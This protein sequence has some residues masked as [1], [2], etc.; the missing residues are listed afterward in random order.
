[1]DLTSFSRFRENLHFET[2]SHILNEICRLLAIRKFFFQCDLACS[3]RWCLCQVFFGKIPTFGGHWGR[4]WARHHGRRHHPQRR[5]RLHWF[6][7]CVSLSGICK[8]S[9]AFDISRKNGLSGVWNTENNAVDVCK[10]EVVFFETLKN[11]LSQ[12]CWEN[13]TIQKTFV[14]KM[15]VKDFSVKRQKRA[16]TF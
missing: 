12:K 14:L 16:K 3:Y 10:V 5:H 13:A 15:Y 1:M 9:K 2:L 6:H 11:V 4:R 8:E 7:W